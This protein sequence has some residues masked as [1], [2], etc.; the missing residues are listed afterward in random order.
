MDVEEN[1]PT[2]LGRITYRNP[3]VQLKT[4]FVDLGGIKWGAARRL[5]MLL[6][7]T[8]TLRYRFQGTIPAGKSKCHP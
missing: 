3:D 8:E 5:P 6:V 4:V 2:T 1:G 7:T